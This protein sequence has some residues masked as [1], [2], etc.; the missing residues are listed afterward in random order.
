M[1]LAVGL[2]IGTRSITGAVFSGTPK[3]FRLVDFFQVDVPSIG[4]ASAPDATGEA[5]SLAPPSVEEVIQRTL[6]EKGLSGADVVISVDAKDCIIREIPVPFT[7]EDQIEKVISYTAEEALPTM[8]IEDVVLEYLKVG[9]S[10]GKSTVVLFAMR[11]DAIESR[12][13]MLKR[14]DVDPVAVDIDAAALYNA[15]TLT[16]LYD[17][18]KPT[19]LIDMGATSTKLVLVEEG[20]LKKVRAFRTAPRVLAPDRMIAQPVGAGAAVGEAGRAEGAEGESLFGDYSIEARFR[21]IEDALRKLE[22]AGRAGR[23]LSIE[24]LD[25][26]TPIAI[27]SDEDYERVREQA[28]AEAE[29][30]AAAPRA[31]TVEEERGAFPGENGGAESNFQDYLERVGREVQ[32]TLASSR[33][34]VGLICLTGGMSGRD[35]ARRYFSEEFDVETIELDFGDSVESDLPAA[36]L[37]DVSRYG[38]VA[39][40]LA[41]KTFGRDLCGLDFRKGRFRYEHRFTRLRFPLLVASILVFAFFLQTTF[42]AYHEY[43]RLTERAASFEQRSREVYKT[44][45]STELSEGRSAIA[46]AKEQKQKWTGKGVGGVGKALPYVE[47]MVDLSKAL[48]DAL[49]DLNG[50]FKIRNITLNLEARPKTTGSGAGKKVVSQAE[51]ST[52]ELFTKRDG[53]NL[54]LERKFNKEQKSKFFQA[55]CSAKSVQGEYQVNMTLTPKEAALSALE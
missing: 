17:P 6:A 45:F 20:N 34:D 29:A 51:K 42:W 15:F 24:D 21:E 23:D 44:F 40:G 47:V 33:S 18:A 55:N 39:V 16:P 35:E 13:S 32:R 12:L 14:I 37:A 1:A 31:G 48:N 4:A 38:A 19:L 22:P 26:S 9:E 25:E 50:E 8:N 36:D 49:P 43:Q 2:D 3:K 10:N 52:V 54:I 5:E 46:A 7:K 28:A 53:A 41:V 11:N 30:G 27:L